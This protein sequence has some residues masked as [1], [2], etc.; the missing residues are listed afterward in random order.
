MHLDPD[1]VEFDVDHGRR[2]GR[3]DRLA[4]RGGAGGEHRGERPTDSQADLAERGGAAGQGRRRDRLQVAGQ[5]QRPAYGRERDLCGA[6]DR[7]G[8]QARLGALAQLTAEQTDQESLLVDGGGAEEPADQFAAAGLG[9]GTGDGG[10]GVDGRVDVG[11][12]QRRVFRRWRQVAQGRVTDPGLPL[13]QLTGQ[14]RGAG[15]DLVRG[16]APQGGGQ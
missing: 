8:Q 14:V 9:T 10:D 2:T 15:R 12:G 16:E 1:A 6:G 11:H 3:L 7:V 13:A 5:Q 4:Y